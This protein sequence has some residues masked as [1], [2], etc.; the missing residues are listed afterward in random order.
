M[1]LLGQRVGLQIEGLKKFRPQYLAWM[2]RDIEFDHFSL[3]SGR[4]RWLG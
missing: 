2:N 4:A 3:P 1:K